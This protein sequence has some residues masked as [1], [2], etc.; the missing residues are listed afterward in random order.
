M[1]QALTVA[2]VATVLGL[3][4]GGVAAAAAAPK[5]SS[6]LTAYTA[7]GK[8]LPPNPKLDP[9]EV[10]RLVVTGYGPGAAV[11]VKLAGLADEVQLTADATGSATDVYTVPRPMADGQYLLTLVG[12][13]PHTPT[14]PQTS[15]TKLPTNLPSKDV[16]PFVVTVP[17]TGFFPFRIGA[18]GT[19]SSS[20][21]PSSTAVVSATNTSAGGHGAG[22]GGLS[23]TGANV[24][25][26][27]VL[28]LI[29][30]L[31]GVISVRLGLRRSGA[32]PERDH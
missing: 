6:N 28:G 15:P 20:V 19:P 10:V 5:P 9:G 24:L 25:T 12:D 14:T 26:P 13:P 21:N 23:N 18:G 2:L 27:L 16:Q 17:N 32:P 1:K 30:V 4:A 29:T 3:A 22:G 8:R 7:Q 11:V 31:V